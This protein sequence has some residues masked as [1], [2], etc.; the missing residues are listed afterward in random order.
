MGVSLSV[1]AE[2]IMKYG[3]ALLKTGRSQLMVRSENAQV[4]MK[5]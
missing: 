4:R 1:R 3:L 2:V 5:R